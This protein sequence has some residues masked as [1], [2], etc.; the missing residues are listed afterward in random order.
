MSSPNGETDKKLS[1]SA[2]A[3]ASFS[4]SFSDAYIKHYE[5]ENNT[6]NKDPLNV[7]AS[8]I[9]KYNIKSNYKPFL[10][11]VFVFLLFLYVVRGIYL[12]LTAI[13]TVNYELLSYSAWS[14]AF[15][16]MPFPIFVLSSMFSYWNFH[17]QKMFFFYLSVTNVVLMI[18][19]ITYRLVYFLLVPLCLKIPLSKDITP[20]MV[21][22]LIRI[23]TGL[24]TLGFLI[25]I[26]YKFLKL[27]RDPD[28]KKSIMEYRLYVDTRPNKKYL[29]DLNI[30]R[31]MSNG[32][33][34][35]IREGER[36]LHTLI[37]GASGTGK[38]TMSMTVQVSNDLDKK[39]L[40]EDKMKTLL[41]KELKNGNLYID[42]DFDD[43]NFN[44]KYFH[45]KQ[46]CEEILN[47]IKNRYRS[48]GMTIVAPDSSM[49][50]EIYDLCVEKGVP[51]NRVDPIKVEGKNYLKPGTIGFN[52]LY[53]S[54][55]VPDW[56][57]NREIIKK[58][59]LFADVMQFINDMKGKGDPYFNSLNRSITTAFTILLEKTYPALHSGK[60]PTPVDLQSLINNFSRVRKYFE[61]FKKLPDAHEFEFVMDFIENDIL[62][63]SGETITKHANGLRTIMNEFLTNP[64]VRSILC[65]ENSVDMDQM[66]A[67]GQVTVVNYALELGATDSVALG[68]FF[69]LSFN[70]AVLRRPGTSNTRLPH[71]Y[72]IDEL[73]VLLHP[74]IERCF[75]LFRKYRVAMSVAIQTLDQMD[76]SETTRYL[77]GVILGC[78]HH[79]IYGRAGITE[80]RLYSELGGIE[81]GFISQDTVSQ[82]SITTANPTISFSSRTSPDEKNVV[83]GIDIRN[84]KFQEV[85]V[86]SLENNCLVR[87]F[88]GKVDFLSS[89]SRM[90]KKRLRIDWSE[91]YEKNALP[92]K[93]PSESITS[94]E[95]FVT[96]FN[97]VEA[98]PMKKEAGILWDLV[99]TGE[100][101]TAEGNSPDLPKRDE[102]VGL[103]VFDTVNMVT[104]T[105]PSSGASIQ[106]DTYE[107]D[108]EPVDEGVSVW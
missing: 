27:F 73:P 52:P 59:T 53:I 104:E 22:F 84:R 62:G 86:Y 74:Q 12:Q 87:P 85:T 39:I 35:V 29:Y 82:T 21:I 75:S 24:P 17:R 94:G 65:A 15:T 45:A 16:L 107:E 71:F 55:H 51:C 34:F 14:V 69:V 64:L 50:D 31:R 38:T 77:R 92:I 66:L 78:G 6:Y 41:V 58:A 99:S 89:R 13:Y 106:E 91:Y 18:T 3:M 61:A 32:A 105:I 100:D 108:D 72:D 68:L 2:E 54:S 88:H 7:I 49:T 46:G 67:E 79:I 9:K 23:C 37:D 57:R 30:I 97:N 93:E 42:E 44:I 10:I 96:P 80:M 36:F 25:F 83:E 11:G 40:N 33:S 81:S 20:E 95:P 1:V 102:S 70:D 90:K 47:K 48:C 28:I 5:E 19:K 98:V 103:P 43:F 76:R 4:A 8:M 56:D 63:K 26:S 101:K 60:Q